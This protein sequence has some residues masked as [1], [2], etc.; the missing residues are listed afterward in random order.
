MVSTTQKL[1]QDFP[2]VSGI[3]AKLSLSF[4]VFLWDHERKKRQRIIENPA[5]LILNLQESV[6]PLL[7]S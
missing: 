2:L 5:K 7:G 1:R 3:T 6:L 4:R